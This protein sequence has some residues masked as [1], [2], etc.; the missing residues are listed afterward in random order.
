VHDD[1]EA[2]RCAGSHR[3]RTKKSTGSQKKKPL[4]T[5]GFEHRTI[6]FACGGPKRKRTRSRFTFGGIREH[7]DRRDED[8]IAGKK[9]TDPPRLAGK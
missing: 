1:E 4:T 3:K 6:F 5:V 2:M 7:G 8:Q 9:Q